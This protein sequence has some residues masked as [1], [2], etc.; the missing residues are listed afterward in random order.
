MLRLDSINKSFNKGKSNEISVLKDVSL[1]FPNAGLYVILGPSGSGKSTL[2][3]LIGAL[4]TPDSGTI[5]Y[6]DLEITKLNEIE[7]NRYRQS[8]VSFIFQENNLIDYLTL[9]D[10]ALLKNKNDDSRNDQILKKLNIDHLI[11]KKPGTLSG[12]EKERCA[13]ARA[14]LSDSKIIL[15]DEP[16]ASLDRKNAENVLSILKEISQDKLVIVVSHDEKLCREFTDNI[17]QIRDG[18]VEQNS[19][20]VSELSKG[21]VILE[22]NPVYHS[23]IA[24]NAFYHAKH[25]FKESILI[26]FLSLIAFFCVSMIVGLAN[27]TR[28]LV[29]RA[30]NELIHYSP[31]TVS[32]YYENIT[33]V[34]LLNV[35]ERHYEI[36]INIDQETSITASLHKNIITD[37]FVDYLT[38]NPQKDTYFAFNSDQAYS[39]IYNENGNYQI[40]DNQSVDSLNDYIESFFGKKTPINTLI[41]D[42]TYFK[43]KYHWMAGSFPSNDNEAVLVYTQ[44]TSVSEDIAKILDLKVGDDPKT[45]IGKTVHIVDHDKIYV[46]NDSLEVTGHFLKDKDTLASE[47]KDL[48]AINNYCI[49]YANDYYDGNVD[50]QKAAQEMINT[51]FKNEVE[52]KTLK[53]YAK[54]QNSTKLKE[55]VENN[56]TE[57]ITICGIAEIPEDTNFAEKMNG[58]LIPKHQLATIRE[59]NSHS[60]IANEIDKHIVLAESSASINVPRIYGYLNMI[61]DYSSGSVEEYLLSYIDF[62]ENRKFFSVNNEISSIEIYTPNPKTKDYYTEKI[63]RY[64]VNKDESYQM[65]YLDLSKRVVGYFNTYFSIIETVLYTISV[66]TLIVSGLLSLAIIYNMVVMRVKEIGIL[67][68]CGYSRGYVFSLIEIENFTLGLVSGVLGVLLA[69]VLSP[70]IN[71]YLRNSGNKA[72]LNNIIRLT[73]GWTIAIILMAGLVSFIAAL[74]PSVIYSRKKPFDILKS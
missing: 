2:L 71:S 19:E 37:D 45:A 40:Y 5:F 35:E 64:N 10:N 30:I 29:D 73:P 8:I 54:I 7:A 33:N 60:E 26:V 63:D 70:L 18:V 31:L 11:K 25:K 49:K 47:G 39:L 58:I 57:T 74:I 12:G 62:F 14:V 55:L 51:L 65:K 56:Q 15:C 1:S 36:G 69:Y 20:G 22:K 59:R 72:V 32:S 38:E 6:D 4:D 34:A 46:Q 23:R 50:G 66:V 43:T 52:T 67:R 68:A 24:K 48:R 21:K 41:Y 16:T 28:V 9:K 42:E 44:H 17:I 53:A 61:S 3:S 27:G 13:I